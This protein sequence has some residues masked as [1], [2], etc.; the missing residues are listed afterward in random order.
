MGSRTTI[1]V[2]FLFILPMLIVTDISPVQRASAA[3]NCDNGDFVTPKWNTT[4][5]RLAKVPNMYTP[6]FE[7]ERKGKRDRDDNFE[8][9]NFEDYEGPEEEWM[10]WEPDNSLRLLKDDF[11][12]YAD[13]R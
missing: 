4:V 13:W 10:T 11:N 9:A 1:V 7:N 8:P 6:D 3:S 5:E 12:H 2:M